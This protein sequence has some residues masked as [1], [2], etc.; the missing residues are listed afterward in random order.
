MI[1]LAPPQAIKLLAILILVTLG[2]SAIPQ[3]PNIQQ[4]PNIQQSSQNK[5]IAQQKIKLAFSYSKQGQYEK[6][7]PLYKE[8]IEVNPLGAYYALGTSYLKLNR[9]KEAIDSF[10]NFTRFNKSAPDIWFN[11]GLAYD[12]LNKTEIANEHFEKAITFYNWKLRS[13]GSFSFHQP[14]WESSRLEGD[15]RT[16]GLNNLGVAYN[17]LDRYQDAITTIK[18]AI[19]IRPNYPDAHYNLGVAY[20]QL[21][22]K[23]KAIAEYKEALRLDPEHT[24]ARKSLNLIN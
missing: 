13:A 18:K 17:K 9:F 1:T 3:I 24:A 7:I 6:A 14:E 16:R 11:L 12:G 15:G 2:C 5:L 21:G 4:N 20:Q 10:E 23:Q 19:K 8:L 22:K